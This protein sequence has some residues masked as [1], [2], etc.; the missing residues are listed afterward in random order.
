MS[1]IEKTEDGMF[2]IVGKSVNAEDF[3]EIKD[4]IGPDECAIV[5]PRSLVDEYIDSLRVLPRPFASQRLMVTNLDYTG[6]KILKEWFEEG[7]VNGKKY[8]LVLCD[9]FDYSDFP[10]YFDT[11]EAAKAKKENPGKMVIVMEAYDLQGD[12]QKQLTSPGNMA[13]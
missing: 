9:A 10:C 8:M 12:M 4:R 7:V 5:V 11:L 6:S 3:P 13:F 2:R 1:S